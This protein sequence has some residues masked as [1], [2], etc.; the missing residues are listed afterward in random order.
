[1]KIILA[2]SSKQRQDIFKMIGLKYEVMTSDV[3]EQSNEDRPDKY[4]EE[5]SLNK[6]KSVRNQMSEKAIIISADTIIDCNGKKYEKPKTKE[7]AFN[8]LK[9]LSGKMNIAY[10]GITIMDLYKNKTISFSSKVD[11]YFKNITD[12]EIKWYVENEKKI[13]KV[14]GYV[15][16]GKASIFIDK[17]D[18]DYN[19]LMGISPSILFEKLK[20]L[21]YSIKD[22][23]FEEIGDDSNE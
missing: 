9:E 12:E 4:V 8:N 11:I 17:I 1:M 15:P 3:A 18:G 22:F 7:E 6:A 10:T 16:L 13:F 2:S 23:D 20:G 14:C 21:G 19:T 5:L